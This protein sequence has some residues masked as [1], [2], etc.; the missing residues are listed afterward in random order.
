MSL[1]HFL[2]MPLLLVILIFSSINLPLI[3]LQCFALRHLPFLFFF[4]I[5]FTCTLYYPLAFIYYKTGFSLTSF[6]VFLFSSPSLS[7]VLLFAFLFRHNNINLF[8]FFVIHFSL[9]FFSFISTNNLPPFVTF[10]NFD[11]TVLGFIRPDR[12]SL[13]GRLK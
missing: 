4:L 10:K 2:R 12:V 9:I 5:F 6:R 11:F 13:F 8:Q 3:F 1:Q 7:L